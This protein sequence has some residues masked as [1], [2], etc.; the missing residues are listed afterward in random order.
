MLEVL[1]VIAQIFF[2]FILQLF[3]EVLLE[4][5]CNA[6]TEPFKRRED[7]NPVLAFVGYGFLG[8]AVGCLSLVWFPQSFARSLESRITCLLL[9]PLLSGAV[10][11]S[12][13]W[14]RKH[15]GKRY[16][17]LDSLSYGSI[18]A[19]GIALVRFKFAT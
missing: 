18:C 2:E 15:R 12:F 14:L 3:G 17:Q 11:A 13:G 9:I 6:L 8:F 19:F 5:G 1:A 16:I 4:L 10:M 7:R